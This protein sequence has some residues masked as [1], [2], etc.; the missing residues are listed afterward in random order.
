[1]TYHLRAGRPSDGRAP[2]GG[3]SG[4]PSD[5]GL[6]A[7]GE[8]PP[9]AGMSPATAVPPLTAGAGGAPGAG[10]PAETAGAAR[11]SYGVSVLFRERHAELVRL[12]VLLVGDR[13]SA[14]DVVQDVFARLCL[15]DRLPGGDGSLPYVRAAVLNGCRSALRRRVVARR[16]GS[17]SDPLARGAIQESAEDEA[18]LAE[19]RRQV[20]AALA[21]LSPRRREVLVLRY[22]LGLTEAEIAAVLGISTGT[23]KSTAA[24]G[25]A[26]L[27]RK[28]GEQS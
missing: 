27:A 16:F 20:L 14:E 17:S 24:R 5:S 25:L 3:A 21:A 18:I 23:V 28:L 15:R 6:A 11:G 1:M 13:P 2:D 7:G 19:D 10:T 8:P 12:A 26:A 4:G 22:W 9:M